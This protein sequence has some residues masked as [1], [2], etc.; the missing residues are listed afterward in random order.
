[1]LN[2]DNIRE[3]AYQADYEITKKMIELYPNFNNDEFW[4]AKCLTLFPNQKYLDFYTGE[5]NYLIRERGEFA[6]AM[7]FNEK[8]C[9]NIL[10]EYSDMLPLILDLSFN[11]ID[12][13][14]DHMIH[15]LVRINVTDRFVIIKNNGYSDYNIIGQCDYESQIYELM[16]NDDNDDLE[17]D[18]DQYMVVD[19]KSI[20]PYFWKIGKLTK[21]RKSEV[22]IYC[23][24]DL[25]TPY[26]PKI[27][28]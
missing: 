22:K 27:R 25:L 8:I 18:L 26:F 5:E 24:N 28:G 10:F 16:K 20:T 9:E 21:E 19:L 3:V 23:V 1:M 11:K 12:D 4:K 13:R 6:L 17:L 2:M 7:D 14:G 15:Y